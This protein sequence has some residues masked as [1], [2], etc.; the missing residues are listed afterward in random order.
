MKNFLQISK[1]FHDEVM[2]RASRGQYLCG[3]FFTQSTHATNR[4]RDEY[5]T[6]VRNVEV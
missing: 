1:L 6:G 3:T 5:R 4:I 2:S